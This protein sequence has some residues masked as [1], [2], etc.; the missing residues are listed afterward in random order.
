MGGGGGGPWARGGALPEP[1]AKA[2][3]E[4][5]AERAWGSERQR[6]RSTGRE[7]RAGGV[8]EG[9]E[10]GA[11]HGEAGELRRPL[12]PPPRR[13]RAS[14]VPRLPLRRMAQPGA[15]RRPRRA[16]SHAE[17]SG[18]RAEQAAMGMRGL[19]QRCV[20][21][22]DG[23]GERADAM[24]RQP[25]GCHDTGTARRAHVLSPS[26]SSS[27]LAL[28]WTPCRGGG[29]RVTPSVRAARPSELGGRHS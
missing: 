21:G 12:P 14:H 8:G 29:W 26:R 10:A 2:A 4:P 27:S 15:Q 11:A 16:M 5:C 17:E 23:A 22:G 1:V 3:A 18:G 28:W 7:G 25:R 19:S 9:G 24:A 13:R 20:V 6:R